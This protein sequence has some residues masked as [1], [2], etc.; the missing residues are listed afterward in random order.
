[1]GLVYGSSGQGIRSDVSRLQEQGLGIRFFRKDPEASILPT[2]IKL[3]LCDHGG[4][5]RPRTKLPIP[6]PT[7]SEFE[8]F[9]RLTGILLTHKPATRQAKPEPKAKPRTKNQ[10]RG[11]PRLPR[12]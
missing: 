9:D 7:G 5:M 1:M 11:R 6:E 12:P 2:A 3:R 10:E 8:N 4:V